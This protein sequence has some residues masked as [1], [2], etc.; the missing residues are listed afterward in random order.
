[1]EFKEKLKFIRKSIGYTQ[2]K[3]AEELG[4]AVIS[5]Q[6]YEAGRKSPNGKFLIKLCEEFP[7]YAFWLMTGKEN[8]PKIIDKRLLKE[9]IIGLEEGLVEQKLKM[10]PNNKAKAIIKLYEYFENKE[11]PSR[12]EIKEKLRLVA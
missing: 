9:I 3:L 8:P 1:M 10:T 5:I 6:N 4:S 11:N 2:N 7:D 12:E